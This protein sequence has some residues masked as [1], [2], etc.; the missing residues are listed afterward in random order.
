MPC[1]SL[2]SQPGLSPEPTDERLV[3]LAQN[4]DAAAFSELVGRHR[5]GVRSVALCFGMRLEDADDIAQDTAS[6]PPLHC[7][8]IILIRK[9]CCRL[10]QTTITIACNRARESTP[11]ADSGVESW[12]PRGVQTPP[13]PPRGVHRRPNSRALSLLFLV[14]VSVSD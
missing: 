7:V 2:Y 1:N 8:G 14:A 6:T 10:Q 12:S 4:G 3:A 9:R 11:G 5:M 13:K